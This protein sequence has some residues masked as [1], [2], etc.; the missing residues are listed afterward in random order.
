MAWVGRDLNDHEAPTPCQTQG[1]QLPHLI[2]DQAAQGPIQPGLEH[3]QGW[4]THKL[5]GQPVPTPFHSLCK[6]LPLDV[7]SKPSHLQLKT[8]PPVFF[9]NAV[10]CPKTWV[11]FCMWECGSIWNQSSTGA[12]HPKWFIYLTFLTEHVRPFTIL[13]HV[14]NRTHCQTSWQCPTSNQKQIIK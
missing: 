13:L 10:F 5:S 14:L 2:L 11:K 3:L 7:K 12:W 1:H 6:E 9:V 4:G 8:I